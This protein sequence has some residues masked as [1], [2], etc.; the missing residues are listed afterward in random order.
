MN[1]K[2]KTNY[3]A[4]RIEDIKKLYLEHTPYMQDPFYV[5][6]YQ[7]NPD[8][9]VQPTER[10]PILREFNI[11]GHTI[12]AKNHKEALKTAIYKGLIPNKKKKKK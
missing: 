7:P 4:D 1:D 11:N 5:P 3:I 9:R 10:V 6:K 8:Y 2:E 12:M